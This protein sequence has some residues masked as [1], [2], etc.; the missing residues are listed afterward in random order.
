MSV[1]QIEG[2]RTVLWK[3]QVS[4]NAQD[5]LTKRENTQTLRHLALGIEILK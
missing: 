3:T 4:E 2:V 5:W 1:T